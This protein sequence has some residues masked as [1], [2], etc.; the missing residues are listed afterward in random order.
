MPWLKYHVLYGIICKFCAELGITCR[1]FFPKDLKRIR[2]PFSS[3]GVPSNICTENLSHFGGNLNSNFI[4]STSPRTESFA[5]N[6]TGS[7][8]RNF[9]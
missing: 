8:P 6:L 5:D 4:Y 7:R 1:S 3:E 2:F 9:Q